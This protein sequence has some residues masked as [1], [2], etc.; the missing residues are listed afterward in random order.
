VRRAWPTAPARLRLPVRKCL[1]LPLPLPLPLSPNQSLSVPLL[2]VLSLTV[3]TH[4][5]TQV[6]RLWLR[7]WPFVDVSCFLSLCRL[8]WRFL[9]PPRS[10]LDLVEGTI[11][12]NFE[13]G[14]IEP[15]MSKVKI[16]QVRTLLYSTVVLCT[17][18]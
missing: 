15:C 16:I 6:Q 5:H 7:Y 11:R 4:C 8:L 14:V 17:V 9:P 2:P 12:N 13:A 1:P 18:V 3:G 10:G